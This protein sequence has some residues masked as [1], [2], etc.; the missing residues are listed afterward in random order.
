MMAN[1]GLA[2]STIRHN[3]GVPLSTGI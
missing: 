2:G 3:A 1:T